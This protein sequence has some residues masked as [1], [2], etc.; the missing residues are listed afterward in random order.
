MFPDDHPVPA[1]ALDGIED[2]LYLTVTPADDA[3]V[4]SVDVLPFVFTIDRLTSLLAGVRFPFA[5]RPNERLVGEGFNEYSYFCKYYRT[6]VIQADR[7]DAV[8]YYYN[9]SP[10][11]PIHF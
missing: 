8:V 3:V 2:V 11:E 5:S 1:V 10:I 6:K 7:Y 4:Y 9:A